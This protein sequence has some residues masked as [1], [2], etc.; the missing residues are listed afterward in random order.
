MSQHPDTYFD[1]V[2]K[3]SLVPIKND[4]YLAQAFGTIDRLLRRELDEGESAFFDVPADLVQS[5][6]QDHHP[7]PKVSTAGMLHYL[8]QENELSQT[9]LARAVGI[10]PS[11][12]SEVLSGSRE[13]SKA[14][15]K[16]LAYQFGVSPSVFLPGD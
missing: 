2:K 12:I 8:L 5:Y 11:L 7:L 3:S 9:Q 6:E 16:T 14:T 13:L 10:P 4:D 15:I 1:H